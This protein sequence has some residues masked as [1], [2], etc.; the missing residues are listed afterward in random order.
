MLGFLPSFKEGITSLFGGGVDMSSW[1][2][3]RKRFYEQYGY[4]RGPLMR[5]PMDLSLIHI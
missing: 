1:S 3:E 4:D 2:P 5:S